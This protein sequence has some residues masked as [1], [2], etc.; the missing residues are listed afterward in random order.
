MTTPASPYQGVPPQRWRRKTLQL[1]KR[2][3][4]DP[5]E[6]L[7]V[8]QTA[9]KD[10]FKSRIGSRAFVIG[11]DIF[12]KPQILGFLLH[13]LIPLRFAHRYPKLWRGELTTREKDMVYIPDSR[14]SIE[15][16]TSS[17]KSRIFGN[18]SFAQK[19]Q[20][21]GKKVKSGY[22]LAV[23]FEKCSRETPKPKIVR[24]RFGWLDEGD[25]RGQ[26]AATGQQ[27]NLSTEVEEAKLLELFPQWQL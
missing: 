21:T 16:K 1:I 14:F 11:A 22:Y 24:V 27:A 9:W 18:R 19:A 20:T 12:P 8:T 6:I 26:V 5:K 15:I 17:S 13:E 2:H 10:I 25:W 7:S 3:P 23:N 4:L